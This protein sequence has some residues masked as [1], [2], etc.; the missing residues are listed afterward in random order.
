MKQSQWPMDGNDIYNDCAAVAAADLIE[1]WTGVAPSKEDVMAAWEAVT[2]QTPKGTDPGPDTNELAF[3]DYW[4]DIGVAGHRI[5]DFYTIKH[6]PAATALRNLK[7]Y[8]G[9]YVML[10]LKR[11]CENKEV[12][13]SI[14]G[15]DIGNHFVAAVDAER[16]GVICISWG[17]PRLITW[18]F[19]RAQV[20]TCVVCEK[21]N[22]S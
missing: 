19:W 12:W 3:L 11:D 22:K 1:L 18:P 7:K 14:D 5:I 9:L 21:E 10:A 4:R 8:N 6:L 2:G 13:A 16:N 17:K 15:P 20:K